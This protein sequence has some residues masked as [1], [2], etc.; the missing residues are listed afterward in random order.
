MPIRPISLLSSAALSM[1]AVLG[2][3]AATVTPHGSVLINRGN[4]FERVSN[5]SDCGPGDMIM[6]NEGHAKITYADGRGGDLQSGQVYTC[7]NE[8]Q[9]L[10]DSSTTAGPGQGG[11]GGGSGGLSTTALVIGGVVIAAG[12]VG[13][14]A[15]KSGKDGKSP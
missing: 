6:I 11:P 14:I 12:V 9:I 5:P 3:A 7:G 10:P 8:G 1:M 4:G 15:S 13:I 2:A